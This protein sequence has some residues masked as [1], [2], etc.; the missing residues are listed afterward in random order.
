[1]RTQVCFLFC[2]GLRRI[3]AE[4]DE[5][6]GFQVKDADLMCRAEGCALESEVVLFSDIMNCLSRAPV[7]CKFE[8]TYA[9]SG[10][11]TTVCEQS[12]GFELNQ[13]FP[14]VG[15]PKRWAVGAQ[16]QVLVKQSPTQPSITCSFALSAASSCAASDMTAIKMAVFATQP[17]TADLSD[18]PI[19]GFPRDAVLVFVPTNLDPGCRTLFKEVEFFDIRMQV[20]LYGVQ[21]EGTLLKF[22][23]ASSA[24]VLTA[25]LLLL[26]A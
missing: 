11:S 2:A 9:T 12:L 26:R 4:S 10:K 25:L 21:V 23:G 19:G 1:M 14:P 16:P 18:L 8:A 6:S 5:W 17:F 20:E 3:L 24:A 7:G 22:T 15:V 13:I